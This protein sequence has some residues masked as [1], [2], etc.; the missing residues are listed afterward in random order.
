MCLYYVYFRILN[1]VSEK[2]YVCLCGRIAKCSMILF[3]YVEFDCLS[4]IS[5]V[6]VYNLV[7]YFSSNVCLNCWCMHS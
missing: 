3:C 4:V 5:V 2:V 1:F 7:V 6:S